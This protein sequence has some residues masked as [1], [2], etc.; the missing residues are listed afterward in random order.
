LI[1]G[2]YRGA[3]RTRLETKTGLFDKRDHWVVTTV[4]VK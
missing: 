4:E 1:V 2:V 3:D